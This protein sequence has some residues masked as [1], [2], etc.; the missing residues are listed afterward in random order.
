MLQLDWGCFSNPLRDRFGIPLRL[1]F[2]EIAELKQIIIRDANILGIDI[3]DDGANEIAKR[4]RGTPRIA[5]RLLKR[6]RDFAC[7]ADINKIDKDLAD[8]SLQKLEIDSSG[9]DSSDRRYLEFIA[10]NYQGG[11]VGIETIA[12]GLS[13][14][15]RFG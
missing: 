7:A 6:V 10:N 3:S 9:L 1:H 11:P 5:I 13:E 8:S 15:K 2:Y 4:S 14:R 12:A